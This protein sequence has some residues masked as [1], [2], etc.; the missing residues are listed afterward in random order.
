MPQLVERRRAGRLG[1]ET[2]DH[3]TLPQ[4][5]SLVTHYT[6]SCVNQ[7]GYARRSRT[8]NGQAGLDGA[9]AGQVQVL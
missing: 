9:V 7:R 3:A 2:V 8:D 6:S 5:E 4:V 1:Q